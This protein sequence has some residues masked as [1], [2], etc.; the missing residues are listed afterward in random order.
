MSIV[1][2]DIHAVMALHFLQANPDI[3]LDSFHQVA[4]MNI[5][6]GIG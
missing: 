6:I 2:T 3:R 4:Q 5:T 1:S